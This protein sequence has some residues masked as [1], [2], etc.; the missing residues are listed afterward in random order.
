MEKQISKR[1]KTEHGRGLG[2]HRTLVRKFRALFVKAFSRDVRIELLREMAKITYYNAKPSTLNRKRKKFNKVKA[3]IVRVDGFCEV[4][5]N[6]AEI[7]HH[8]IQLNHGGMNKR[9]NIALLCNG[10]HAE[11]H[12]WLKAAA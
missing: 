2:K 1:S 4:C 7:R 11:I 6:N 8:I 12:P 5:G 9:F 10:C 3:K